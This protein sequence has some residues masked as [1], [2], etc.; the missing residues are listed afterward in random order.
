MIGF[1]RIL[2]RL[3]I[4]DADFRSLVFLVFLTLL[5]GTIFYSV[6]EGWG[7]NRRLL[8][9]RHHADHRRLWRSR[10]HHACRQALHRLLHLKRTRPHRSLHKCNSGGEFEQ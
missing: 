2:V 5:T 4:R 10:P 9:Q 8:L 6:Q 1:T 3:W 7:L